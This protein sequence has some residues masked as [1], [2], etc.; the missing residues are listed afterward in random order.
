MDHGKPITQ[1]GRDKLEQEL[2]D[3]IANKHPAAVERLH[4]A[5]GMGDLKENSEYAAAKEALSFIENR[6]TE[7]KNILEQTRVINDTEMDIT[8][9]GVGNRVKVTHGN[10]T[11]TVEI[12]GEYEA[13]PL[14]N[15]LSAGSPIGKALL[16]KRVNQTVEIEV[17]AGKTSYK[18]VSIA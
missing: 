6:M 9:V 14:N 13:D 7:L 1:A 3:L 8:T 2:N 16:G 10:I 17:P 4:R 18:I 11:E 5:R 12:V 15:K